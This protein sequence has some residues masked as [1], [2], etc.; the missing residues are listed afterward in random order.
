MISRVVV[1][2]T[3]SQVTRVLQQIMES[4]PDA[5]LDYFVQQS[6]TEIWAEEKLEAAMREEVTRNP[7]EKSRTRVVS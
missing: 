1:S 3:A 2:S 6:K 5:S 4:P 7:P